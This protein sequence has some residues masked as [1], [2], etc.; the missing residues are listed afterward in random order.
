MGKCGVCWYSEEMGLEKK[1]G[2]GD[3]GEGESDV[4]KGNSM[5]LPSLRGDLVRCS[6]RLK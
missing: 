4:V 6:K 1:I 2:V 5:L 3:S